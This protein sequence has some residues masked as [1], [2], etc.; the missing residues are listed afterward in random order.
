M[1]RPLRRLERV[2]LL[3]VAALAPA[4]GGAQT[5][6]GAPAAREAGTEEESTPV[7]DGHGQHAGHGHGHG[8][9]G[10]V[11]RPFAD[12]EE[13]IVHLEQPDRDAWQKPD[14]VVAGLGL[15][16]DE[17][18]VD[19]GA[20]SG[21]FTFRLA[22]ALPRGRVVATD[23]DPAMR[24]HLRERA[25]EEGLTNVEVREATSEDSGAPAD[26]DVV[27]IVNVLHHVPDW[28]GWM[29]TLRATLT[30][31]ARLVVVEFKPEPTPMGP[32]IEIRIA[33]DTLTDE[34]AQAGWTLESVDRELLP[35]HYIETFRT[36]AS[37]KE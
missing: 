2:L 29:A 30:G 31:P 21:Y 35:Y 34:G 28:P 37:R 13:Y 8:E 11:H 9:T 4:C 10:D 16:G 36:E 20:G 3:L 7:K 19:V 14:A 15:K 17:T 22:R 18:V 27:L 33:P 32:P 12:A 26:A 25:A 24:A 1:Y 23:L 5:S 6:P